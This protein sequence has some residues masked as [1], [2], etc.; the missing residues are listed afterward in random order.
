[1]KPYGFALF[2]QIADDCEDRGCAEALP[3]TEVDDYRSGVPFDY[4]GTVAEKYKGTVF[5]EARVEPSMSQSDPAVDESALHI[6]DAQNRAGAD[7]P[8][9]AEQDRPRRDRAAA[10]AHRRG[11]ATEESQQVHSDLQTVA[12]EGGAQQRQEV[13]VLGGPAARRGVGLPPMRRRSAT[14]PC[15]APC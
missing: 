8:V 15:P 1:M 2:L 10:P 14:K 6:Y 5:T 4:A 12:L 13:P 7:V 11:R 3:C 9:P